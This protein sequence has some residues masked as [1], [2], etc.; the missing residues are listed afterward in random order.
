MDIFM[1]IFGILSR[2]LETLEQKLVRFSV[3]SLEDLSLYYSRE[4]NC[5]TFRSMAVQRDG[6]TVVCATVNKGRDRLEV[7]SLEERRLRCSFRPKSNKKQKKDVLIRRLISMPNNSS[8]VIIMES[9]SR[10]SL[11][12]IKTKRMLRQFPTFSGIISPNGALGIYL[13]PKGGLHI[14]DMKN[15]SVIRTLIDKVAEVVNDTKICF[16]PSGEH[17]LYFN[18]NQ[19]TLNAFRVSDGTHIGTLRPHASLT[20]WTCDKK[21]NSV[22]IGCQDGSII[23]TILCD[24]KSRYDTLKVV[25]LL[26]S[27]RYLAKHL[28]IDVPDFPASPGSNLMNLGAVTTAVSKFKQL[29]SSDQKC[30]S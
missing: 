14:I 5:R 26:P 13:S 15:G 23:T 22:V 20:C 7:I 11:W 28:N 2:Q 29:L 10:G 1:R 30:Q 6:T 19:Q 8:F 17:I 3:Y 12:S 21:N 25:A 16:T 4:F 9:E 24:E 27:R 18:S